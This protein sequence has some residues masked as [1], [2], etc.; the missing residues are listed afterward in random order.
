[1]RNSSKRKPKIKNRIC[2]CR[3]AVNLNQKEAAFL[4]GVNHRQISQWERGTKNPNLYNAVG[5]AV[6]TQK[7]VE[8]VFFDYR[9]EWKEK[10]LER[11]KLFDSKKM[12]EK[13][14]IQS[15]N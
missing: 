11:K 2:Y 7:L 3:K 8:D 1:M 9:Q 15:E 4:M 10:I 6:V 14:F 13:T 5:L 12:V